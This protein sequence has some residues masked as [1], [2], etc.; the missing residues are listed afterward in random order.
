ME[1]GYGCLIR[2]NNRKLRKKLES[3]GILNNTAINWN[4]NIILVHAGDFYTYKN[5]DTFKEFHSKNFME[6]FNIIDCGENEDLF[7]AIAAIRNNTDKDQWFVTDAKQSWPGLGTY[8]DL[9]SFEL[10]LVDHRYPEEFRGGKEGLCSS[11]V[12]A[13][14]ATVE[15]LIKHFKKE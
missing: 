14:K 5:Y 8:E 9:G 2:K 12:P 1:D 6:T 3:F 10:C 7:L 11:V 13:H 15:E 4:K